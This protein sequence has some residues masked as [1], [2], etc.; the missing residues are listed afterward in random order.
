MTAEKI[1]NWIINKFFVTPSLGEN[2]VDWHT[3]DGKCGLTIMWSGK[4]FD[5]TI[6][7]R[8]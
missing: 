5:V 2:Y 8:E 6:Q 7:E 4:K 3:E 1:R